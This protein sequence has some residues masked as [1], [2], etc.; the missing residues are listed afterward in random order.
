V[1][2]VALAP[3]LCEGVRFIDNG[4]IIKSA[5]IATGID[6]ALHVGSRVLDQEQAQK[7]AQ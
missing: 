7:T 3:Q 4:K 2:L 1:A 6:V 5:G